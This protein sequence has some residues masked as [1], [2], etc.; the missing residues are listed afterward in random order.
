MPA[1]L[2]NLPFDIF[3]H[4]ACYLEIRDYTQLSRVCTKFNELLQND[5]TARS[6]LQVCKFVSRVTAVWTNSPQQRS[7]ASA[8]QERQNGPHSGNTTFRDAI[9][10]L[11]L[12]REALRTARPYSASIIAYGTDFTYQEGVLCYHSNGQIRLLDIRHCSKTEDYIETSRWKRRLNANHPSSSLSS[13]LQPR[14][15]HL[16]YTKGILACLC[17]MGETGESWLIVIDWDPSKHESTPESEAKRRILLCEQLN[18]TTKLFIQHNG[19]YLYYGTHSAIGSHG[20]HEWMIQGFNLSNGRPVTEK[21]IQLA[22]FFGSELGSTVCFGIHKGHFYAVSNQTSLEVEEVDW[23]SQYHCIQFALDERKP[24]LRPRKRWRRQHEEGP[25]NDSWTELSLQRAVQTDELLIVECRK[26]YMGGGSA[27]IRTY[28]ILP[29][30]LSDSDEIPKNFGYPENDPLTKTLDDNSKPNYEPAQKR[31]RRFCHPEY[32]LDRLGPGRFASQEF[33]LAKTKFRGYNLATSSFI[34]LVNDPASRPGFAR[35]HDRIRLRIASRTQKSPL[36]DDP[37]VPGHF[38]LRSKETDRDGNPIEHSEEDF[39]A[40]EVQNLWPPNDAPT[41]LFDV[42]CPGGRVGQVDAMA[43]DMAIVYMTGSR[44]NP[45]GERAIIL[46][47]FDPMWNHKD[48]KRIRLYSDSLNLAEMEAERVPPCNA[49]SKPKRPLPMDADSGDESRSP[50]KQKYGAELSASGD[51]QQL[52][53]NPRQ[54]KT[55]EARYLSI[56]RG[57]RFIDRR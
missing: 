43:D 56:K 30:S 4:I 33:I 9:E 55:E 44:A 11:F 29:L 2:E 42:L 5:S 13:D 32:S 28:Y 37:K 17:E 16:S 24:I 45:N 8:G 52:Q 34:D 50:K 22:D 1:N 41:E 14:I 54:P 57:Y 15:S 31:I 23:T 6:C 25:L 12:S 46:I 53:Q 10:R 21:P 26:E 51:V 39:H 35:Q 49:S 40:T 3:Y 38:L 7:I 47:N 36:I 18:C 20:H 27:N 19:S 48:M